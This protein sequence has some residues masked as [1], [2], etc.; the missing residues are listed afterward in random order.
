MPHSGSHLVL[1]VDDDV[2]LRDAIADVLQGAGCEVVTAEDGG[3]ALAKLAAVARPCLILLDLMMP[4]VDGWEFLRRLS[5]GA[6]AQDLRVLVISAHPNASE[7]NIYPGVLGT[8][9]K[10]FDVGH[11]LTWVEAHC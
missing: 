10:P 7:A 4:R 11:L 2:D 6:W 8:L 3:E 5:Q 9:G 1:L